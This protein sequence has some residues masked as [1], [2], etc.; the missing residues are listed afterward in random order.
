M[1]A[2]AWARR[3]PVAVG[4]LLLGCGHPQPM[5]QAS[6]ARVS[7]LASAVAQGVPGTVEAVAGLAAEAKQPEPDASVIADYVADIL[8][9][10]KPA[11]RRADAPLELIIAVGILEIWLSAL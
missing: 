1:G 3:L 6:A 4:L 7:D 5:S 11:L 8:E 10:I 9:E 2:L